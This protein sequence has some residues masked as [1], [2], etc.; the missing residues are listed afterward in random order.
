MKREKRSPESARRLLETR[1]DRLGL[2]IDGGHP[3]VIIGSAARLLLKS[4]REEHGR[5]WPNLP[6]LKRLRYWLEWSLNDRRCECGGFIWPWQ[7][8]AYDD[9]C[10]WIHRSCGTDGS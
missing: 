7:K 3:D 4:F 6:P 9:E 5:W 2:L 10:G 8:R 1:R